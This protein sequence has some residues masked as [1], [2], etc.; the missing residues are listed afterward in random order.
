[1]GLT[2]R[3]IGLLFA[4]FLALLVVAVLRAGWVGLVRADTLRNAAA[5]QQVSDV[6]MPAQR[7]AITDRNGVELAVSEPA[8]DVS[9]TPY[10]VKDPQGTSAKLAPLLGVPQGELLQKLTERGGFVYLKR[11]LPSAQAARVRKLKIAGI[12]LTPTSSREYP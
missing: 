3:R 2:Q 12:D 7:G 1:M 4:V 8:S 5:T 9:A 10:L 6:E 11:K